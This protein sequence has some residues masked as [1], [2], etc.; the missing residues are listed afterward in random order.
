MFDVI[1][2]WR[3]NQVAQG[4]THYFSFSEWD[5]GHSLADHIRTTALLVEYEAG[6]IDAVKQHLDEMGLAYF[7]IP[8]FATDK[9]AKGGKKRVDCYAI[10]IPLQEA[11]N[12]SDTLRAASLVIEAIEIGGITNGSY[13]AT[14]LFRFRDTGS[15]EFRPGK[16][17]SRTIMEDAATVR[18]NVR[19]W[20]R[21][22]K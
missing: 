7:V 12:D 4:R 1:D 21:E 3:E 9:T 13:M 5:N 6:R 10:A 18:T 16:L 22:A 17:F 20:V 19:T 8:T 2:A 15:A 14:Y 11:L